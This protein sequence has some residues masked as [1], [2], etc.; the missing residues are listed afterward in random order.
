MRDKTRFNHA[1]HRSPRYERDLGRGEC[2]ARVEW[3]TDGVALPETAACVAVRGD[4][5]DQLECRCW[6]A[7]LVGP[8]GLCEASSRRVRVARSNATAPGTNGEH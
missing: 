7:L 3:D 4:G 8:K 5:Y 1:R 6:S 2:S